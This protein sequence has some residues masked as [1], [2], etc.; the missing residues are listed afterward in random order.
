MKINL[1]RLLPFFLLLVTNVG[2]SQQDS[3]RKTKTSGWTKHFVSVNT[4]LPIGE[5]SSTHTVGFGAEYAV[6]FIKENNFFHLAC[7]A[8]MT[9]YLGKR[10]TSFGYT[11]KYP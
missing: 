9:Y 3:V 4:A 11:Y 7:D 1:K 8:G 5:F 2:I 6:E 10:E